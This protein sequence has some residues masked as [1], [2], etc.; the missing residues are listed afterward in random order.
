MLKIS[1]KSSVILSMVL[2][3]GFTA[4]MIGFFIFMKPFV[5]SYVDFRIPDALIADRI[6]IL[7]IGYLIS[8]VGIVAGALLI[9]LLRR[10]SNS[11]VFSQKSV[12]YVRAIS[13]CAVLMGILFLLLWKYFTVALLIAFAGIF[14]G[15]CVR[16][17]KNVIEEAAEIKAEN[18][19][20]V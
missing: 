10:V 8:G 9:L 6:Y 3:V 18:D 15:L 2:S 4:L 11:L 17:V 7:I 19:L 16:V 13:W 1:K 5:W 14:L 12:A 20:T